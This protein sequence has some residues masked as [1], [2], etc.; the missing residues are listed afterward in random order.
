MTAVK[1]GQ[2][3]K[4]GDVVSYVGSTGNTTGPHLH[5]EV[6]KNGSPVN[7]KSFIEGRN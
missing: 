2:R 5:Y 7:P 4:K 1:V 3:V 6:W